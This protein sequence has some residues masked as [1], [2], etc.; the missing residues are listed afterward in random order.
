MATTHINNTGARAGWKGFVGPVVGAVIGFAMMPGI[1]QAE[2]FSKLEKQGYAVGKLTKGKAG[3]YGW[4]ISNSN[5]RFFCRLNASLAYVNKK[6]MVS[7]T[8]SGRLIKVDRATFETKIGG[9]DP[10]IP[11]W[12]DLQSGRVKPD[13]VGSCTPVR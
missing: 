13:D 11:Q 2:S 1:A 3:G 6:E 5:K 8:S 10:S 9:P 12:S 7:I 4:V